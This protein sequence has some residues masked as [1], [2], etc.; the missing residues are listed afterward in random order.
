MDYIHEKGVYIR[1]SRDEA[2]RRDFKIIKTRWIDINKGDES[3]PNCRNRFVAKE[4]STG[5]QD[6][7][8]ASTPPLEA[9]RLLIHDAATFSNKETKCIMINDV[10]RA[11]FEAAC[12][13]EV[14]IELPA[15]SFFQNSFSL[16]SLAS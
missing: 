7:L 1:I 10:S 2:I 5:D 4:F 9:L 15:E 16:I 6:G 8:F 3:S 11:F 14:C 12:H 13:R